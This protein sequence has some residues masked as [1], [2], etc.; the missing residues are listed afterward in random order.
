LDRLL[1][2]D[3]DPDYREP[4]LVLEMFQIRSGRHRTKDQAAC[5]AVAG[6]AATHLA[7]VDLEGEE[8]QTGVLLDLIRGMISSSDAAP[9]RDMDVS[10]I[11]AH[12][13][14]NVGQCSATAGRR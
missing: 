13:W 3:D 5:I 9:L 14:T 8:W 12:A 4:A 6:I 10:T 7:D 11:V 2:D 1:V